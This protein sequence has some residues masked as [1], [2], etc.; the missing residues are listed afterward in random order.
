MKKFDHEIVSG[1]IFRSIWK[2]AWPVVITQL[3]AGVHGMIDQALVGHKDGF[4]GQAAV[5]ASWQLFL[6]VVVFL[7]LFF[8]G[9]NILIAQYVGRQ[10][11]AAVNRIAYHTFL[12]STYLLFFIIAPLGYVLT[13]Y[14]LDLVDVSESVRV[15]AQPYLRVLFVVN[16]PLFF[17]FLLTGAL[18][19]SGNAKFP[20]LFGVMTALT[21]VAISFVFI[22]GVG[23][24]P[25]LGTVGA[26]VGTV[27]GPIPSVCIAVWLILTRRVFVGPPD[28]FTLIP[29]WTILKR[30]AAIGLPTGLQ[31]VLLNVGGAALIFFINQLP[32]P[33]A[34]LAAY[35]ICYGQLFNFVTWTGFGLRAACATVIG[36]NI[37]AGKP[38]RG[39]RAVYW[40]AAIGFAWALLFGILYWA[41]PG[42]LLAI[43]DL[44]RDAEVTE[45]ARSFLQFL[46]ISGVFVVVMLAFTGGLQGAGD[47]KTPMY[48][49][50]VTQIGI[51]LGI[52]FV[53]WRMDFLTPTLIWSAILTSHV[54]R[55]ALTYVI[56]ARG[57]WRTIKVGLAEPLKAVGPDAAVESAP[58]TASDAARGA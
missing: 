55:L 53:A 47:T 5:G 56:F 25:E 15:Y 9:M 41:V 34:A 7:S 18:Q 19:S 33:A 13:P 39:E 40:G 6:V 30:S 2:V 37:G 17:L 45:L 43:F 58:E 46:S 4:E 38:A 16:A 24:F 3:V 26:A 29:D 11:S 23:P 49:A 10:D 21:H 35:T 52:C 32:T 27:L 42:P 51:L 50:F 12:A 28:R 36:Q 8:Q 1:G 22:N 54:T 48:I 57:K 31:A 20:L 44:A 14:L